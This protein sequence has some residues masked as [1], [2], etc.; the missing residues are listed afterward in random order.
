LI[1]GCLDRIDQL[2]LLSY[3]AT[4]LFILC[5]DHYMDESVMHW[6]RAPA[7]SVQKKQQGQNVI[8]YDAPNGQEHEKDHHGRSQ[9]IVQDSSNKVIDGD[10]GLILEKN[11]HRELGRDEHNA[12]LEDDKTRQVLQPSRAVRLVRKCA[13]VQS[14]KK[15]TFHHGWFEDGCV[16]ASFGILNVFYLERCVSKFLTRNGRGL[17]L[18]RQA[19]IRK[20]GG[21]GGR[22][23]H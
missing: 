8:D 4:Y 14:W 21:K 6:E 1:R 7:F 19:L 11:L 3:V 17:F 20:H 5:Y 15:S 16:V 23:H 12:S 10:S 9:S 18:G 2:L 13:T 22:T